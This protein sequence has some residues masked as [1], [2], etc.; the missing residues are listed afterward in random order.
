[1][2][3]EIS[4]SMSAGQIKSHNKVIN[5]RE[6]KYKIDSNFFFLLARYCYQFIK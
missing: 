2:D 4:K 3:S 1:M 5:M 6:K